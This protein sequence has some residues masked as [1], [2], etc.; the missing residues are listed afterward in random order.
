MCALNPA[1]TL[2]VVCSLGSRRL[3]KKHRRLVSEGRGVPLLSAAEACPLSF[4]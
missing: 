4:P 2:P 1:S 3:A